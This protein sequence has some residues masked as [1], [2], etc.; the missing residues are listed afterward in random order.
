[1]KRSQ[2]GTQPSIE[3][4]AAVVSRTRAVSDVSVQAFLAAHDPPR[5][6]WADRDGVEF[7]GSGATARIVA[8]GPDRIERVRERSEELLDPVDHQGP[9]VARPRLIGG[10]TFDP[11]RDSEEPWESFPDAAFV[12]PRMWLVNASDTTWLSVAAVDSSPEAVEAALETAAD[13]LAGLPEG[14][15]APSPPGVSG[16]AVQPTREG[17]VDG[18]ER[19]VGQIRA[20]ALEKVVLS[21]KLSVDLDAEIDVPELLG[22]LRRTYPDCIL[23]LV[24]F[25]GLPAF[26]GPTP[27]R[28][29]RHSGSRVETEALAGSMPRGETPES[30]KQRA[31]S[32]LNDGKLRHEQELVVDGIVD[33][34]SAFGPVTEGDSHVR[35]L[36]NVQHLETPITADVGDAHVLELV[37]ALHPTPAI[38]G[39]PREAAMAAIRRI[40]PFD[41]G[42]YAGPIGWFDAAGD[43]EFAVGIRSA[44]ASGTSA[45]LFAGNGIVVDSDPGDEWEEIQPK[46]RPIMDALERHSERA[47]GESGR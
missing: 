19:A 32:L 41:R 27:E 11:R 2:G 16:T 5:F 17:W 42:W 36:A 24:E 15:D 37:A 23:F 1:M 4:D 30:D 47:D 18:V 13:R 43:G 10:F 12:L 39:K 6:H 29:V 21:T 9:A 45:T 40:E 31:R 26:F 38:G 20:G 35:K 34:L 3:P 44:I 22:G 25:E 14:A 28:L 7:V 46:Y 33:D 8:D